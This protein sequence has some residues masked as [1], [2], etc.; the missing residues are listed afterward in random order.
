VTHYSPYTYKLA[1]G[2]KGGIITNVDSKTGELNIEWEYNAGDYVPA[3]SAILIRGSQGE[4]GTKYPGET[5]NYTDYL[6]TDNGYVY[7]NYQD[8]EG[9]N[10]LMYGTVSPYYNETEE[11]SQNGSVDVPLDRDNSS[12]YLYY[13]LSYIKNDYG[14]KELGCY[15]GAEK[16][17]AF[18]INNGTSYVT[19]TKLAWLALDNSGSSPV[20]AFYPLDVN[21]TGIENIEAAYPNGELQGLGSGNDAIYNLQGM[22][23]KEIT[24]KGI[25]IV[26]GK[27]IV[28]Q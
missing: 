10:S 20:K 11:Y 5:E 16:G 7:Q 22:K 13:K 6:T 24:K 8:K 3:G 26:N 21:A 1:E 12:K 23:V 4:I 14:V 19:G 18:T 17:A 25:Y 15:W 2:L 27:K 28:C 9:R